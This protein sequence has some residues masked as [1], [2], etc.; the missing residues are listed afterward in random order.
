MTI[1]RL[2]YEMSSVHLS[3]EYSTQSLSSRSSFRTPLRAISEDNECVMEPLKSS[4]S[5]TKTFECL[6]TLDD[7]NLVTS[8]PDAPPANDDEEDWGFFTANTVRDCYYKQ[9]QPRCK[10]QLGP[11]CVPLRRVIQ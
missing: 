11:R 1:P 3:R 10:L 8:S 6:A 2:N 9:M 7:K 4:L 5:K